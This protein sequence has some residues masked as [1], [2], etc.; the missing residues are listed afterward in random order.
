MDKL[1]II[2]ASGHGKVVANIA[3]DCEEWDEISFL[4]DDPQKIGTSVLGRFK[5]IDNT[6]TLEPYLKEYSFIVGIGDVYIREKITK[7]LLGKGAILATIIHPSVV[8]GLDV[9]IGR[10]TVIMPN[11]VINCSTTIGEG[12]I[13]N[14]GSTI[15][16]DC[17]IESFVHLSPGVK[18]SGTV[19][20]GYRTWL[21]T[22]TIVI[23]NISI[24]N[25]CKVGAG[26]VVVKDLLTSGVY[27][28][29]PA[30]LFKEVIYSC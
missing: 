16:H 25:D 19:K 30:K 22:G 7:I 5:V 13:V 17:Y 18:I 11:C 23:N 10:G 28:G 15:D 4:D 12:C 29:V 24:T 26:A 9:E 8:I 6:Q 14:T 21:G 27:I 3:A 20:I 1:L 2:G